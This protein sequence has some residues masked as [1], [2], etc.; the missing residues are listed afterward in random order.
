M[1]A[2]LLDG[3]DL[4][5]RIRERLTGEVAAFRAARGYAPGLSV[6]RVGD[7]PAS[8]VYVR[9]KEAAARETGMEGRIVHLPAGASRAAVF[10]AIEELAGDPRVHGMLVQL[11]LPAS[12]DPVE[13]QAAVPPGKDVDGFHPVN[14]GKLLLG[15][16]DGLVACTPLGVMAL[17]DDAHVPLA[18]REV[19][20]VGRS[21]I[22]GKPVAHLLLAR[23]A[24][25]TLCHSRT[26]DL[27]A[28]CRRA[29][30][31]V[32]AVGRPGLVRREFIKPGATVVDVGINEIT[33]PAAAQDQLRGQPE[34]LARF[35]KN[36]KALVGD[37]HFGDALEV[38]GAVTPVPGGVGPLT[39]ALLLQN[40]LTAARRAAGEPA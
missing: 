24:T 40:T 39:V 14:A 32:A 30:V 6:V 13:V 4:A 15:R 20:V 26:H 10:G 9:N 37:V 27:A 33:D 12:F 18:G 8:A 35:A 28:V 19:V 2:R 29:D 7:D 11:P 23:H 21:N 3:K 1:P 38:A 31:L 22:V 17:L 36:G 5:R 25:V 16:E 34:R